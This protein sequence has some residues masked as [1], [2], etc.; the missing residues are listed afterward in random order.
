MTHGSV[1][2]IIRQKLEESFAPQRLE[3]IDESDRHAGHIG[4]HAE[5][6]S[7][8]RIDIVSQA[9]SGKSRIDRHRMINDVL[10]TLLK[11]RVHA[12]AIRAN[13][14]EDDPTSAG[15]SQARR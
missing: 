4:A 11:S 6:E 8:F 10:A 9:F 15:V 1:A 2:Q 3:V 7:H 13:A 14:P 5:G 12:L